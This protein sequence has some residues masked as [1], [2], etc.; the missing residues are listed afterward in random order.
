[1]GQ[2]DD[3]VIGHIVRAMALSI[4]HVDN[5]LRERPSEF[6]WNNKL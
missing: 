5:L 6:S 2:M 4:I 3:Y 1:M